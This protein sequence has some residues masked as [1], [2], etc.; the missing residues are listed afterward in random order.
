MSAPDPRPPVAYDSP[1][2][3]EIRGILELGSGALPGT[4]NDAGRKAA[5]LDR[6]RQIKEMGARAKEQ[7]ERGR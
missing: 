2:L 6:T 4:T 7:E 3:R 5:E 1:E